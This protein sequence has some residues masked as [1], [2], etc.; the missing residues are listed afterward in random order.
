[1]MDVIMEAAEK[2]GGKVEVISTE[3][4]EGGQFKELGGVGAM[5]RYKIS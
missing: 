2:T 1:L 5:L 4:P 3:T